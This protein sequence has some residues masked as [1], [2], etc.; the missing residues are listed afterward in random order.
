MS[1]GFAMTIHYDAM[2]H[3]TEI[4]SKCRLTRLNIRDLSKVHFLG[5]NDHIFHNIIM[6]YFVVTDSLIYDQVTM[7]TVLLLLVVVMVM[8]MYQTRQHWRKQS[9]DEKPIIQ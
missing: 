2:K 4:C 6:S 1:Q 9:L 8:V 3:W 7:F 5:K